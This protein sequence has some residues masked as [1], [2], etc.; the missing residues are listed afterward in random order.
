MKLLSCW[1]LR[2]NYKMEFEVSHRHDWDEAKQLQFHLHKLRNI[3]YIIYYCIIIL[4]YIWY[5]IDLIPMFIIRCAKS[6]WS[7]AKWLR[8]YKNI[9]F[10]LCATMVWVIWTIRI[11]ITIE[12][13]PLKVLP[14]LKTLSIFMYFW[15]IRPKKW[16][17][18]AFFFKRTYFEGV[19]A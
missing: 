5:K 9:N 14:W 10:V 8:N 16:V 15:L 19:G 7:E 17:H 3:V 13:L 11:Y 4:R 12:Q 18:L 6:S 2:S 1:L